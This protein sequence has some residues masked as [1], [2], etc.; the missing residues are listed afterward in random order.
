MVDP[1]FYS[2]ACEVHKQKAYTYGIFA[3][4]HEGPRERERRSSSEILSRPLTNSLATSPLAFAA[5]IK[6]FDANSRQL[7]R[8][9]IGSYTR[10]LTAGFLFSKG[11]LDECLRVSPHNP[12]GFSRENRLPVVY[13]HTLLNQRLGHVICSS[14]M[15]GKCSRYNTHDPWVK[16]RV[17]RNQN[18]FFPCGQSSG[19]FEA[20]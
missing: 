1:P 11:H 12:C 19:V 8:L 10:L 16:G 4:Y 7:R 20:S 15:I 6:A 13:S 3:L 9:A 14:P 2:H 17:F 18:S 5:K